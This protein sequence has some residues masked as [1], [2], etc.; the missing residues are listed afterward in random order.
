MKNSHQL[1]D[2]LKLHLSEE[3]LNVADLTTIRAH[4]LSNLERWRAQ[5]AWG[6][7]YEEWWGL[8]M[9]ASDD[10]IIQMMTGDGDEPNRLRQSMPYVGMLDDETRIEI[11]A[12][13]QVA[14]AA[15][16]ER[17]DVE[18]TRGNSLD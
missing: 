13:Y 1:L 18:P 10:C 2:E 11:F 17:K 5:G 12:K 16:E 4:S 14:L 7:A 3:T 15:D 8:M 9:H 6:L